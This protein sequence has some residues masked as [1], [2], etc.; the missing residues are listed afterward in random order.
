MAFPNIGG[1]NCHHYSDK[2]QTTKIRLVPK[3]IGLFL[4]H[5]YGR[6]F[7]ILQLENFECSLPLTIE[8][9][10]KARLTAGFFCVSS[11]SGRAGDI[12]SL[13]FRNK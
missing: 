9:T 1:S 8:I 13:E 11:G 3:G 4:F 12:I 5:K 6:N 2:N 7:I 10:E